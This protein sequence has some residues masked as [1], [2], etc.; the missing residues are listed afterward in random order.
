MNRFSAIFNP[1]GGLRYHLRALQYRNTLWQDFILPLNHWLA[2]WKPPEK[3]LIIFG[4]SGG[5][6]LSSDFL[7]RFSEILVLEP[8]PIAW[9]IFKFRFRKSAKLFWNTKDFISPVNNEFHSAMLKDFI[10]NH[11]GSAVFF[12]NLLGQL[13]QLHTEATDDPSFSKWKSELPGSLNNHSWA[14]F[15]DR[16]S[17][18]IPPDCRIQNRPVSGNA[19][20]N[21]ELVQMFYSGNYTRIDLV[22]HCTSDLFPQTPKIYFKWEL[23]PGYYHLIEGA[24]SRK[25]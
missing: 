21:D 23:I 8:D 18:T 5:Y 20:S 9:Q 10:D 11:Q 15:H 17:G 19:F 3:K 4:S 7:S 24:F 1:A 14:S 6:C 22:D 12:T 16:V 25:S 2:D 13:S